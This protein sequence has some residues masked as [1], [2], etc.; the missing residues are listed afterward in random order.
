M[1]T[2]NKDK[3]IE[4]VKRLLDF[5]KNIEILPFKKTRSNKQNKALHVY[6][7]FISDGLNELG[8]E[9]QYIGIRGFGFQMRYT[10]I[11]IK[12]IFWKPI[13]KQLFDIDSTT[14]LNSEMLNEIIDIFSKFFAEKG[15][16]LEFPSKILKEQFSEKK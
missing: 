12:E 15:V 8:Q 16:Y 6:F 2:G 10:P 14:Q 1:I 7:K 3:A 11:I 4:E 5:N 9:F 13:Q